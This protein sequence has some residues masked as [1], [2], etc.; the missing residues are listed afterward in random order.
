MYCRYTIKEAGLTTR[1]FFILTNFRNIFSRFYINLM[2]KTIYNL[3]YEKLTF[4]IFN[5]LISS[6]LPAL[7]F[8]F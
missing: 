7:V 5:F 8:T 3:N 4:L 6:T 1:L 2:I